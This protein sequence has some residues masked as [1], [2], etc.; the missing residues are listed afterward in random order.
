M[1]AGAHIGARIRPE[2]VFQPPTYEVRTDEY[3]NEDYRSDKRQVTG[4]KGG[5]RLSMGG[6]GTTAMTGGPMNPGGRDGSGMS[7]SYP[8]LQGVGKR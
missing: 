2:D 8:L 5:W 7:S 1:D 4:G 3:G 6:G